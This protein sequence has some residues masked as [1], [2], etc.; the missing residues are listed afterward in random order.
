MVAGSTRSS[1]AT[2]TC[3]TQRRTVAVIVAVVI[4]AVV[5]VLCFAGMLISVFL[6][7]EGTNTP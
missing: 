3:S 4:L 5:A 2:R 6:G 1:R 7:C